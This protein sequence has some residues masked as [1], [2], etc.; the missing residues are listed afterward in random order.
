MIIKSHLRLFGLFLIIGS[1]FGIM[2][3]SLTGENN[4]A[5]AMIPPPPQPV[6]HFGGNEKAIVLLLTFF[7]DDSVIFDSSLVA[8]QPAP[9]YAGEPPLLEAEIIDVK[10]NKIHEFN[11][12]N[13]LWARVYN[14]DGTHSVEIQTSADGRIVV[15]FVSDASSITIRDIQSTQDEITIDLKPIIHEFCVN[16][17]DDTDCSISDLAIESIDAIDPPPLILLEES[18]DV[19]IQTII[20]NNG[21][22]GPTDGV[23]NQKTANVSP[24]ISVTPAEVVD[25]DEFAIEVKEQRE[26]DQ[27][28]NIKCLEPGLHSVTFT[29]HITPLSAA[30]I[31]PDET[32][33]MSRFVLTVDCAVPVTINIKPGFDT[34]P[35]IL[36]DITEIP[37]AVLTTD[38]GEYGNPIAFDATTID[39]LTARFGIKDLVIDD[40]GG[41]SESHDKGIVMDSKERSDEFTKD[42]DKDMEMHFKTVDSGIEIDDTE[43]CIKGKF[44]D[45]N[46]DSFTFFGCDSVDIQKDISTEGGGCL[47]ATATYGSELAPQVQQLREL[48]DNKLLQ[49]QSGTS[50][51]NTFNDFYYSISPGIADYERENPAFKELVKIA[52][53]PMISSLTILNYVEMD[54]EA[55]MLGYGISLIL[56]NIGMYFVAP[57][58]VIVGIRKKFKIFC[59]TPI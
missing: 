21:P 34:N 18:A 39:P 49:T 59:K 22:D 13:P 26:I 35:I 46:E 31:D 36:T 12:W 9:G 44:I 14:G 10:D 51:M 19:T 48:R 57:A 41:S 15:P 20:A 16:N 52:I 53:T 47:I 29:S 56:L 58:I 42:G 2:L 54:S 37:L 3:L 27:I 7:N 55:Q 33:N 43:A 40:S 45:A 8:L 17:P 50:F 25:Q 1:T 5:N 28:Y 6:D 30:V 32:N 23:F 24:E 38:K 11:L 4:L